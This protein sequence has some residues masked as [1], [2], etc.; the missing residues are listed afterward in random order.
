[1]TAGKK[2]DAGETITADQVMQ[3]RELIEEVGA[4]KGKLLAYF[5]IDSIESMPAAKFKSAVAAL[6]KKRS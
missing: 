2:A 6:Q 4:D 5:K 3:L 1:M